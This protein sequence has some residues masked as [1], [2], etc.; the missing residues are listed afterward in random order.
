MSKAFKAMALRNSD[1]YV[2]FNYNDG[3]QVTAKLNDFDEVG[4]YYS[5][6]GRDYFAPWT[7]IKKVW[8]E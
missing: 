6:G 5:N 8:F 1:K 7:A 2:A 3:G 4:I